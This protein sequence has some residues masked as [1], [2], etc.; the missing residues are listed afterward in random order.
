MKNEEWAMG[1]NGFCIKGLNA[2]VLTAVPRPA[3]TPK[4]VCVALIRNS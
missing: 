4:I 2:N 1:Q 3:E